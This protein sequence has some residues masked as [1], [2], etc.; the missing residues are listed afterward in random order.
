MPHQ[1]NYR[2]TISN[3]N[4]LEALTD[5]ALDDSVEAWDQLLG[6]TQ[7]LLRQLMVSSYE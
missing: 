6:M 5:R 4:R 2:D 7:T 3:V 1:R